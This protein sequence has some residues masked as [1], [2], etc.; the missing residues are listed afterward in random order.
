MHTSAAAEVNPVWETASAQSMHVP[1]VALSVE[2]A[3]CR[4]MHALAAAMDPVHDMAAAQATHVPAVDPVLVVPDNQRGT[5]QRYPMSLP[6]HTAELVCT[7]CIGSPSPL[8]TLPVV[9]AVPLAVVA[10]AF[11]LLVVVV[12]VVY[13]AATPPPSAHTHVIQMPWPSLSLKASGKGTWACTR[14]S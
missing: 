1:V 3:V 14:V 5:R 9:V 8:Q 2:E 10:V 11:P 6:G 12:T 7:P 13:E 4:T